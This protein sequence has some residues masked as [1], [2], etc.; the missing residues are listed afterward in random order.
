MRR[1]L[2]HSTLALLTAFLALGL[3]SG[4]DAQRKFT[5]AYDQPTTTAYGIAA[6]VFEEG[7][8]EGRGPQGPEGPRPGHQDR[9]HALP[10]LWRPDRAHALR[11]GVHE[12]AD[13]GRERG[14]ERRQRVRDEQALRGGADPEHD[15]ARG[16]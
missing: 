16:E 10:G 11:R 13:R 2:T 9:G 14:R 8:H 5:F 4:A 7:D 12:P 6:N 1:T 3:P 15:P